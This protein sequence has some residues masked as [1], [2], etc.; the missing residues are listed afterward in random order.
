VSLLEHIAHA[1][2]LAVVLCVMVC[3]W[4][5]N[6]TALADMDDDK[7][8]DLEADVADEIRRW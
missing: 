6:A 4:I 5:A 8:R 3:V 1:L 7:R 2:P